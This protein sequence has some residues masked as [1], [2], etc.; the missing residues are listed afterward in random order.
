METT[1][2]QPSLF[3]DT[4]TIEQRFRAWIKLHPE[5]Y[6]HFVLFAIQAAKQGRK[7]FGSKAIV[8]RMRW[9]VAMEW[10]GDKYKINNSFTALLSRKFIRDYPE[11]EH[12]FETR[13]RKTL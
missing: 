8:E 2:I 3:E 11:Y 13:Q 12:L 9:Y 6:E 5:A 1:L 7:R 10:E 4:G